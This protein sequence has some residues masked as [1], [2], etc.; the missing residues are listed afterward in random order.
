MPLAVF[1]SRSLLCQL[2]WWNA[3]TFILQTNQH[4]KEKKLLQQIVLKQFAT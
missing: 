1:G 3:K 4:N 2:K